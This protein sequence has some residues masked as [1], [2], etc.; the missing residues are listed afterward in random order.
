[1]LFEASHR[2]TGL[3]QA[4]ITADSREQAWWS[5]IEEHDLRPQDIILAPAKVA[6]HSKSTRLDRS[7]YVLRD[8]LGEPIYTGLDDQ[9]GSAA[10]LQLGEIGGTYTVHTA[11]FDADGV[12]VATTLSRFVVN[13]PARP[14][15]LGPI[16]LT[17][18]LLWS[19]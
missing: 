12:W 5:A 9:E 16:N 18:R 6:Y 2:L 14:T 4:L 19:H 13:A 15:A 17:G 3:R 10:I 8:P 11:H 7:C 1:M